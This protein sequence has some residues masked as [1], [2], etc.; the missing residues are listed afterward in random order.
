MEEVPAVAAVLVDSDI[1]I[2]VLRQRDRTIESRWLEL[3]ASGV[4][5]LYSP[6]TTA[7]VW[8]GIRAGEQDAV[9]TVFSALTCVPIDAKIGRRAGEYLRQ[10]FSSHHVEMGDALIAATAAVHGLHLWTRNK[11]H[12]PMKE[13]LLW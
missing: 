9:S 11:K 2:E 10:F 3:V 6:V 8:R 7:E 12:Y 1:L 4:L 13:V 5:I